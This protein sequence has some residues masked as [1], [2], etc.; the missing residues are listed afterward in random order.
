MLSISISLRRTD[1]VPAASASQGDAR[2]S[3]F[4]PEGDQTFVLS[5]ALRPDTPIGAVL[6]LPADVLP[7]GCVYSL[8]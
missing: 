6:R 3:T 2:L 7:A 4:R 8:R 1:E 5:D